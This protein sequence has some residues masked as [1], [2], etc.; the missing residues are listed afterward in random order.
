MPVVHLVRH[1][2]AHTGSVADESLTQLGAR[3]AQVVGAALRDQAVRP[4]FVVSGTLARQVETA[5]AVA[6]AAHDR[7]S[8]RQDARWNEYDP[9][10]LLLG[11]GRDPAAAVSGGA[12]TLQAGLDEALGAW[13]SSGEARPGLPRWPEFVADVRAA[14]DDVLA[15]LGRGE[16][17]VVVTSGGPL[18]TI[19]AG[20]LQ[21]PPAGAVALHR[22]LV[23]TGITKVFTGSGGLHLSSFNA[24]GHLE[25]VEGS[26]LSYR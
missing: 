21:A 4:S 20:C 15:D 22:V 7:E 3:Q 8:V 26:L 17:A 9:T 12:R 1:G 10:S 25:T 18:T 23:N 5:E 11:F 16:T 13:M 19:A 24:H 2:Q 14:L 6:A